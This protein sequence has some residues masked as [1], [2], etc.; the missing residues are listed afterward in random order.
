MNALKTLIRARLAAKSSLLVG[1]QSKRDSLRPGFGRGRIKMS[2]KVD[3][4][5]FERGRSRR[6][7]KW[8]QSKI[9]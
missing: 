4:I 1:F 8:A 3:A 7:S 6:F 9:K 5:K 2:D